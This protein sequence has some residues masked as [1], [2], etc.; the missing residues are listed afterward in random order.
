VPDQYVNIRDMVIQM[1]A[2]PERMLSKFRDDN[3]FPTHVQAEAYYEDILFWMDLTTPQI[4]RSDPQ[5]IIMKKIAIDEFR[6][7]LAP[8]NVG[9]DNERSKHE[10]RTINEQ[11]I[12]STFR[13][14]RQAQAR[15]GFRLPFTQRGKP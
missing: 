4:Y 6:N 11:K 12:T 1:L 15:A 13:D 14:D 7:Y 8:R 5:Y 9:P 2:A 3:D 10:K